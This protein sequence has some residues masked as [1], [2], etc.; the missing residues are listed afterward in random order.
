MLQ[1][2]EPNHL[3]EAFGDTFKVYLP[4]VFTQDDIFKDMMSGSDRGD[5]CRA[6][7]LKVFIINS[8]AELLL[9]AGNAAIL[10]EF[11]ENESRVLVEFASVCVTTDR[12]FDT[13]KLELV[14]NP[15][16]MC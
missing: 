2:F 14:L 4:F 8:T 5:F 16:H 10:Q 11:V 15:D 12:S 13:T 3:Q 1:C 7:V 6:P 9:A